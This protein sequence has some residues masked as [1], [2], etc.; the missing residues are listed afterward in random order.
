MIQEEIKMVLQKDGYRFC[1]VKP[2]EVGIF[3][4]Y[5]QE[6]FHIVMAVDCTGGYHMTVEQHQVMEERMKSLFFHPQGKIPDFP[7]GFPV[8]HV[9]ALTLLIGQDV[10]EIRTLCAQCANVWA[11]QTESD[12][13]MIYENQPGD[14][15]G[16]RH[17]LEEIKSQMTDSR[18]ADRQWKQSGKESV[19]KWGSLEKNIKNIPY[20]TTVLILI[21][22]AVFVVLE[23][24][25]D[26]EDGL[27]IVSHGGMHPDLIH[28]SGQWWRIFTA[29]FI[30][31]GIE[32]L[33][34]NMVIFA[35]VGS[36][37]ERTI[38]HLRM[39]TVYL[40]SEIGGGLLS[41]AV[42]LHT[43]DFAVSAGASGA[44]FGIIGGLLWAVIWHR[45]RLCG[46]TTKGIIFMIILSLYF[47][48]TASGVD[49]WAHIGGMFTG[50]IMTALLYHK[51]YQNY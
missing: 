34:N 22:V 42:M 30:H 17:L 13:L 43:G 50:F 14:F 32:H 40:L 45:G 2:E 3:Y 33:V 44:I 36:R 46:L 25:G 20:I 12:R 6:G 27:F 15:W 26:T 1:K 11:Y 31:F 24:I 7:E 5:Y 38:G 28:Y 47:G 39:L 41:Y 35:C 10:E 51:K 18:S 29:G 8:Y 49:N 23:F 48:F 4:K 37:L 9:E 21:N 19:K 16:L